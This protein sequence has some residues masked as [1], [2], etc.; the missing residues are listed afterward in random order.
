[1]VKSY[2]P[3][4]FFVSQ[5]RIPRQQLIIN[6]E[7]GKQVVNYQRSTQRTS[8]R[9]HRGT[10]TLET[11][12]LNGKRTLK[13]STSANET[14]ETLW[15]AQRQKPWGQTERI[16]IDMTSTYQVMNLFGLVESLVQTLSGENYDGMAVRTPGRS[17]TV[18]GKADASSKTFA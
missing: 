18:L 7:V 11:E 3:A 10:Y 16:P 13:T 5:H 17:R 15:D 6:G 12:Y 14:L 2:C 9:L 1:M 8:C 4:T